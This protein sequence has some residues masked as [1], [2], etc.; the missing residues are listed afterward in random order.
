[1]RIVLAGLL[2]DMTLAE[3]CRREG[4]SKITPY[5]SSFPCIHCSCDGRLEVHELRDCHVAALLM[6]IGY[7]W[8]ALIVFQPA[9]IPLSYRHTDRIQVFHK[10]QGILAAGGEVITHLG[11]RK[12]LAASH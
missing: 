12:R 6:T 2:G 4:I 10:R 9:C 11:D 8:M 5:L 7:S 3:L 1:M